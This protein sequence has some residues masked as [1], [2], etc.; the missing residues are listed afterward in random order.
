MLGL[1]E[2]TALFQ[3]LNLG[4]VK[5]IYMDHAATTPLDPRVLDAM[6]PFLRNDWGNPSAVYQRGREARHAVEQARDTVAEV[7]GAEPAEIVFTSGGTEANNLAVH[8]AA[9]QDRTIFCTGSEHDAILRPVQR[10]GTQR[11]VHWLP[12]NRH[13]AP[14][15]AAYAAV[16]T[17]GDG[18]FVT[19]MA[20]NNETGAR[21]D[22]ARIAES[23]SAMVHTD[24]VQAVELD[25]IDVRTLGV[26]M[27][28]LSAHKFGGPKGVGCL[29]VRSGVKLES[30][31]TGGGQERDRRGGTENVA[32]IVGMATALR[33]AADERAS[34]RAH[35]GSLSDQ[36][37]S[38]LTEA[39]ADRISFVTP[40]AASPHILTVVVTPREGA[41]V[42]GEMLL[43]NLDV[44]GLEV[45]SG[46][47]C[48][49][50]S[51]KPS[52]VL[53]AA[54]WPEAVARTAIRF[55]LGHQN[56][57]EEVDRAIDAF[58]RVVSR[59]LA[60]RARSSATMR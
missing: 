4:S 55:S 3:Q 43:L 50:G 9:S 30:V 22:V 32:G 1:H 8:T 7:I 39:M 29:F 17:A 34:R 26:D 47:A 20:V 37:R 42:D 28:S 5:R 12:V 54:G 18:A 11:A 48:S 49:S 52:H 19:C 60:R 35:V 57:D 36:L 25:G 21:A 6:L 45:S 51:V 24:A 16:A 2:P 46:A 59:M 10:T 53:L 31:V 15:E 38:G 44:E 14:A 13:G 27:L 23:T 58:D 40:Q 33:L 41:T 56:T